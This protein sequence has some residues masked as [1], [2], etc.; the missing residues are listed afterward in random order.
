MAAPDRTL[1]R[2][3]AAVGYDLERRALFLRSGREKRLVIPLD[4][5]EHTWAR[6]GHWAVVVLRPT[7]LPATAGEGPVLRA[8]AGLERAGRQRAAA[9]AYQVIAAR[10]P[11]SL[12]ALIG[13]GNARYATGDLEEA[14]RAFRRA[15]ERHPGAAAAWNNL[16]HVLGRKGRRREAMTAA[17]RAVTLA[18]NDSGPFVETLREVQALS[19]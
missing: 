16:A 15:T 2:D 8:A 17:R 4:T 1:E 10:W 5:F 11:D 9:A 3:L 12:P 7:M 19:N 18:G 13:F 14:E 6:G